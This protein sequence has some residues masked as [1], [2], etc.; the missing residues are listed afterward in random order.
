MCR[1]TKAETAKLASELA[2]VR[3]L[4]AELRVVIVEL[5]ARVAAAEG[6]ESAKV[7]PGRYYSPR[8]R[9]PYS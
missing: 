4:E 9:M 3:G 2:D 1:Y 5:E 8:H 7:W 6:S